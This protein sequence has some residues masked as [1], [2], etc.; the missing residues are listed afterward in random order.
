M[1]LV[2]LLL[3]LLMAVMFYLIRRNFPNKMTLSDSS[4]FLDQS[5]FFQDPIDISPF[6]TV[7]SQLAV[8]LPNICSFFKWWLD[9]SDNFQQILNASLF[10]FMLIG[11]VGVTEFLKQI[12]KTE[13]RLDHQL[14]QFVKSSASWPFLSYWTMRSSL[15]YSMAEQYM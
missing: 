2:L 7:S 8:A 14:Y 15:R 1:V 13:D 6:V 12:C 3:H 4:F 11:S 9:L 5:I 10:Q